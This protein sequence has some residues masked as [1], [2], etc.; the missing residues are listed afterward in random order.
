MSLNGAF[1]WGKSV[2]GHD[3]WS[4]VGE[5]LHGRRDHLTE[6]V[7]GDGWEYHQAKATYQ[8]PIKEND[9]FDPE[10]FKTIFRK[11]YENSDFPDRDGF[12]QYVLSRLGGIIGLDLWKECGLPDPYK[13]EAVITLPNERS[14]SI[15]FPG[16]NIYLSVEGDVRGKCDAVVAAYRML[17]EL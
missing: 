14:A 9:P 2:D 16:G 8:H 6:W 5:W 12:K 11:I 1:I 17:S 7:N 4:M 10:I 13:L 3:F 15:D